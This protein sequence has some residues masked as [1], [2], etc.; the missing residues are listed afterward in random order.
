MEPASSEIGDITKARELVVFAEAI[1]TILFGA[2]TET[3]SAGVTDRAGQHRRLH[4]LSPW[5]H[6][7]RFNYRGLCSHNPLALD[8]EP[9]GGICSSCPMENTDP[10]QSG[11]VAD[12]KATES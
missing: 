2:L 9:R 12:Y 7:Q 10:R 4:S 5:V 8:L 6:T 3:E 1:F 11:P